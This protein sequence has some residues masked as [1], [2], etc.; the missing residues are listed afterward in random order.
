MQIFS[1]PFC[2]PRP[3]YEF[4][5]G[6]DQGNDRPE[7]FDRVSD[8]TWAEYLSFR[9]NAKGP[10]REVWMHVTCG[11]LFVMAR[12]SVTMEAQPGI[13]LEPHEAQS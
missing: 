6:G 4:H 10:V 7:G 13:A 1:C 2:G 12:D 11:E 3:E 8:Q 5:F 9:T